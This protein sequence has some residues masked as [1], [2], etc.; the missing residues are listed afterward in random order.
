MKD[1][2]KREAGFEEGK[3]CVWKMPFKTNYI[4]MYNMID[5]V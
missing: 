1:E 2:Y 4:Y 5:G 3:R